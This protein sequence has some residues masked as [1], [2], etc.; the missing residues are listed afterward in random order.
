MSYRDPLSKICEYFFHYVTQS[1]GQTG[2]SLNVFCT[3]PGAAQLIEWQII[4]VQTL[5]TGLT[6]LCW[7][8]RI[9]IPPL[10]CFYTWL[11]QTHSVWV[12]P[13]SHRVVKEKLSWLAGLCTELLRTTRASQWF[14]WLCS[15]C[16][17]LFKHASIKR[18]AAAVNSDE[19]KWNLQF[20]QRVQGQWHIFHWFGF[21]SDCWLSAEGDSTSE[22][23]CR[24]CIPFY[25]CSTSYRGQRDDWTETERSRAQSCLLLKSVAFW[26]LWPTDFR[27]HFISFPL[28]LCQACTAVILTYF[29]LFAFNLVFTKSNTQW[30]RL[31]SG[32]WLV[33]SRMLYRLT[34]KISVIAFS[35][36]SLQ[37]LTCCIVLKSGE[38]D[39][40]HPIWMWT[41]LKV[42]SQ[43]FNLTVT[44]SFK[45]Q[46]TW[47]QSQNNERQLKKWW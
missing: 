41:L 37:S 12:V 30:V 19:M 32:Q 34:I 22:E 35:L 46:C 20:S 27:R 40:V 24:N 16:P 21:D 7:R 36:L 45:I 44:V 1:V 2:E 10:Y 39:T 4:R 3:K 11:L 42:C 9:R 5:I 38:P 13:R 23:Q 33:Q 26:S 28:K 47:A 43:H 29:V 14:P 6:P 17:D 8:A 18:R 15:L 25:A 31:Q